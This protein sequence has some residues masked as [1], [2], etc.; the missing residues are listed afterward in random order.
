MKV[1]LV[2]RRA[3]DSLE[4]HLGDSFR[5][6]GH[7]P[8]LVD[9][10]D[11]LPVPMRLSY[12]MARF[13]EPYDR[14]LA[15]QLARRVRQCRPDLVLVVYRHLHPLLVDLLKRDLP[16]VPVAQI[17]P[18][19]LTNLEQQQIIGADYDCYFSKE[20]YLVAFLRDKAG[21]NAH[22]LPEAFN[23]RVHRRPGLP[24]ADAERRQQV[25]VL[26]YGS[27]YA[28]RARLIGQL[29]RAGLRLVVYGQPGR[30][31]HLA[32]PVQ[33][34]TRY[35]TGEE[36]N[37]LVYG[38]KVVFNGFHY[39]EVSSANQKYFE[40]NGIG[41]FQLCDNKPMVAACTGVPSDKVTFDTLD[42]AIASIRQYLTRP[43]ERHELADRQYR[44]FQEHHTFDRRVAQLLAIL[45]L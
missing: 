5:A 32:G 13:A 43:D 16:G 29:A 24:K 18:D 35:L 33:W 44:H 3:F 31:R 21:L 12:W 8:Q 19:A 27:L 28:Y 4:Y 30:Y 26:V 7:H 41:G 1:V 23:P 40:I 37:R 9:I 14:L 17:N 22:Y 15:R 6:L 36:K 25:D 42:E 39:A 38:A 2:G 11:G 34:R 20:P 10:T 45:D